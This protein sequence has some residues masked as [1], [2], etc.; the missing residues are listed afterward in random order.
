MTSVVG[1][2]AFIHRQVDSSQHRP[3]ILSESLVLAITITYRVVDVIAAQGQYKSI[4][5]KYAAANE[6]RRHLISS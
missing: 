3:Q 2:S 6:A 5:V 4:S 1:L